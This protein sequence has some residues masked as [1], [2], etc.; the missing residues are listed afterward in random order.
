MH[1]PSLTDL[2]ID[3]QT[4]K[5]FPRVHYLLELL[6]EQCSLLANKVSLIY[7]YIYWVH[8]NTHT[9]THSLTTHTYCLTFWNILTSF[10]LLK[11]TTFEFSEG[12][13]ITSLESWLAFPSKNWNSSMPFI[14]AAFLFVLQTAQI[15]LAVNNNRANGHRWTCH[16]LV[17]LSLSQFFDILISQV[18]FESNLL[19]LINAELCSSLNPQLF[20]LCYLISRTICLFCKST[21]VCCITWV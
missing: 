19:P 6:A 17:T 3:L 16:K 8:T 9:H 1:S 10:H 21:R 11:S 7:S 12:Y 20:Q 4:F 18:D 15:M 13:F 2:W 5:L 14:S